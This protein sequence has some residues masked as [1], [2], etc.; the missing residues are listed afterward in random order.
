[1]NRESFLLLA[2][3][4]AFLLFLLCLW[5]KRL[6]RDQTKIVSQDLTSKN[7]LLSV[8]KSETYYSK[9]YG[10]AGRP[11]EVKEECGEW[12]PYEFK[13][14]VYKGRVYPAHIMQLAAYCLLIEDTKGYKPSYGIIEY[15]NHRE[16]IYYTK[17]LRANLLTQI[18]KIRNENP[19]EKDLPPVCEDTRKCCHC[20]YAWYYHTEQKRLF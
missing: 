4:L 1:M 10:I 17:D 2:L 6:K 7:K 13:S 3:G 11:D 14:S 5:L 9:K 16:P 19:E 15:Q 18:K 8:K 20:G 12:I